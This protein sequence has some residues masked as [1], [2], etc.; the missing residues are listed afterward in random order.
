MAERL[1]SF[2]P[3]PVLAREVERPQS[4]PPWCPYHSP[5]SVELEVLQL[6]CLAEGL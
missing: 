5:R 4:S 1:P 2:G 6:T 3:S